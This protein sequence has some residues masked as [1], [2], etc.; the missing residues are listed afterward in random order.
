[1]TDE[2]EPANP[3]CPVCG[4]N[5]VVPIRDAHGRRIGVE[6]CRTCDASGDQLA[7]LEIRRLKEWLAEVARLTQEKANDSW[8]QGWRVA[9]RERDA[10]RAECQR[11][12]E[13]VTFLENCHEGGTG[14]PRARE[15]EAE[16]ARLRDRVQRLEEAARPLTREVPTGVA[17]WPLRRRQIEALYAALAETAK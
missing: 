8:H 4:G 10:A 3:L 11:L 9:V 5:G 2:R 13:R 17:Q 7:R 1:M 16:N 15:M 12:R 6:V 14:W